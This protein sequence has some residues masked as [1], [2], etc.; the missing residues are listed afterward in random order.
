ML[1]DPPKIFCKLS[2]I[3]V[4]GDVLANSLSL[5]LVPFSGRHRQLVLQ[6]LGLAITG[7]IDVGVEWLRQ[8]LCFNFLRRLVDEQS[9]VLGQRFYE[10][11]RKEW[12]LPDLN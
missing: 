4:Q 7:Q 11:V 8:S 6:P 5:G 12:H 3:F 1:L 9:S 2:R 10:M